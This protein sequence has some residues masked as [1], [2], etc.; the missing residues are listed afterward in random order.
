[1]ILDLVKNVPHCEMESLEAIRNSGLPVIQWGAGEVA[2]YIWQYLTEHGI[3]PVAFCDSNS[4]K[5]GSTYLGLPVLSYIDLRKKFFQKN[6]NYHIVISTGPQYKKE[7]LD[8]L[9]NISEKNAVWYFR[10]Y[11]VCG[12]KLDY[13]FFKNKANFFEEVYF[14]LADNYSRKVLVNVLNAKISGNFD[15][16]KNIKSECE[17]FD[18]EII[19]LGKKEVYLDIGSFNGNSILE[20]HRKT[21]GKYDGIIALEPDPKNRQILQGRLAKNQIS[22]VEIIESGAWNKKEILYFHNDRAGGSCVTNEATLEFKGFPLSVDLIDNLLDDRRITYISMD[23]EGSERNALLGAAR[24][25]KKWKPKL[26]ISV[27]HRRE[28]LFDIPKLIL[29]FDSSYQLYLRHYTD[30]QTETILYAI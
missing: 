20:F 14:S 6:K 23:I 16:Y 11:E 21:K 13:A 18:D 2:W 15:L 22:H 17:Y 3:F 5:H 26:A 9:N 7:I 10:G 4:H 24:I 28:D 29:S 27:Y 8:F 19:S 12:K 25:I 1:M 30:N